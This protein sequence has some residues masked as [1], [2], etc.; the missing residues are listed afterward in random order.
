MRSGSI[1]MILAFRCVE[2]TWMPAWRPVTEIAFTPCAC[3]AMVRTALDAIS[4][5][6]R[7]MSISR[8]SG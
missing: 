5:V 2:S 7:S 8:S 4:P 6:A 1:S 3:R